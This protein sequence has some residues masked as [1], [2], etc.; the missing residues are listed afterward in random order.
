MA[1]H[2]LPCRLSC[3]LVGESCSTVFQGTK[4]RGLCWWLQVFHQGSS[5]TRLSRLLLTEAVESAAFDEQD[6][7]VETDHFAT[8]EALS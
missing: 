2:F 8:R 6:A 1:H 5:A 3:W 7:A 4:E